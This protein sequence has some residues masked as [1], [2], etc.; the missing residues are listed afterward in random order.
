MKIYLDIDGTLIHARGYNAGESADGLEE[1]ME[2]LKPYDTYWL[3]TH[4]MYGDPTHAQNILKHALPERLHTEVDRIKP[5]KWQ[6]SKTEALDFD[7]EFLWLDD[8]I[9]SGEEEVLRRKAKRDKQWFVHIDLEV[10][11]S[12]LCEVVSD[13]LNN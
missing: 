7:S 5:T 12:Q 11:P 8:T 13:Y 1:L 4:C 9:I 2:A 6:M 3:T 10:N